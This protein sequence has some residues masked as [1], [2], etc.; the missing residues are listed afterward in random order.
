MVSNNRHAVATAYLFN[1][2]L[3]GKYVRTDWGLV[4]MAMKLTN[5]S[6]INGVRLKLNFI[7]ILELRG[8]A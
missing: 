4:A 2:D 8:G 5:E 3:G 6:I 1:Q 7:D